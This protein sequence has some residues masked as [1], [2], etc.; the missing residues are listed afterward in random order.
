[1]CRDEESLTLP[2][3]P[4]TLL[5]PLLISLGGIFMTAAHPPLAAGSE[6]A[7]PAV[8]LEELQHCLGQR[9][10]QG[11]ARALLHPPALAASTEE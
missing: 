5:L 3:L 7:P 2:S 8:L 6:A 9:V 1:M 10:L 11:T 4:L